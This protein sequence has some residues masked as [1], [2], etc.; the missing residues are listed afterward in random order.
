VS[1]AR[2]SVGTDVIKDIDV[3]R[4]KHAVPLDTG[5]YLD[6]CAITAAGEENLI[7]G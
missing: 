5:S 4:H 7:T 3:P 1:G 2:E 6:C